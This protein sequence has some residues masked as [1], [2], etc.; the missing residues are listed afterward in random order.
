[1][2]PQESSKKKQGT[3]PHPYLL[4]IEEVCQQLGTNIE[5]G[6]TSKRAAELQKEYPPNELEG[7]GSVEWYK[8]LIKQISNA[9]ILVGDHLPFFC[10][11]F[12][13]SRFW[14]SPW[15]SVLV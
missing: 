3:E 5:S 14:F 9:M 12:N 15:V 11:K 1:M 7:G 13:I 6:L 4:P 2:A 8:I 10:C